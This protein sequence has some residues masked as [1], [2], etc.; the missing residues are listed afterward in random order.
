MRLVFERAGVSSG[1]AI[2]ALGVEGS[3]AGGGV[4]GLAFSSVPG[5]LPPLTYVLDLATFAPGTPTRLEIDACLARLLADGAVTKVV[6]DAPATLGHA[7]CTD[8]FATVCGACAVV[9]LWLCLASAFG[10]VPV[11]GRACM[12]LPS[13]VW[14]CNCKRGVVR[15][16]RCSADCESGQRV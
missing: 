6:F 16:T 2:A 11:F 14:V 12:W 10:P 8:S 15:F 1:V 4:L 13:Q 9:C 3:P 5:M 7:F